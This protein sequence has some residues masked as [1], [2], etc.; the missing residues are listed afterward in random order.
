MITPSRSSPGAC[1][2]PSAPR[3]ATGPQDPSAREVVRP[4]A[5]GLEP[6]TSD[7]VTGTRR[8]VP[9]RPLTS[10]LNW[11]SETVCSGS[12]EPVAVELCTQPVAAFD[13]MSCSRYWWP[14]ITW[15]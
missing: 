3:R 2:V 4:I 11:C 14:L 1:S 15:L 6:R 10:G 13:H 7:T 12:G 9:S 5:I 8:A